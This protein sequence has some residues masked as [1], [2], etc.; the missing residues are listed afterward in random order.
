MESF[1]DD[2]RDAN[3]SYA[4]SFSAQES[5]GRAGQR[6]LVL[7]CMDSRIVP[8]ALF[9]MKEGDMK[10]IRNA[11]GQLN[12]EVLKDIIIASHLLDCDRIVILPHT[13]CAMAS[14]PLAAMQS[15][16]TEV[17]GLDFST[18]E[19]RVIEDTYGTLRQDVLT[20]KQ[21]ALIKAGIAIQGGIYNVDDG[22][23]EWVD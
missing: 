17:S 4:A 22:T 8:H 9:G 13:R 1:V 14:M 6:L 20:L 21:H 18:F 12:P 23:I 19:P 11:G 3:A 2:V 7:T 15:C 16:L 5:P 10:V